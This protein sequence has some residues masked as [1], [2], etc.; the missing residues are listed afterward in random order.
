MNA[1]ITNERTCA[2]EV[3]KS[4]AAFKHFSNLPPCNKLT[5]N[6]DVNCVRE[7]GKA[8]TASPLWCRTRQKSL[9]RGWAKANSW[10][11][12]TQEGNCSLDLRI[13]SLVQGHLFGLL[14]LRPVWLPDSLLGPTVDTSPDLTWNL[15]LQI[16]MYQRKKGEA[17]D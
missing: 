2:T 16:P 10:V 9:G 12:H 17:L 14:G 4:G 5:A 13:N 8:I 6:N 15:W 3:R 7:R 11:Q 1:T